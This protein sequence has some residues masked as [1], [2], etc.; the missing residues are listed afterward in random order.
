[1]QGKQKGL[2]ANCFLSKAR[3]FPNRVRA[4]PELRASLALK[5]ELGSITAHFVCG[6][7]QTF[8]KHDTFVVTSQLQAKGGNH[9]Q[10]EH[11]LP[12]PLLGRARRMPISERRRPLNWRDALLSGYGESRNCRTTKSTLPSNDVASDSFKSSKFLES[13]IRPEF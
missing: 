2:I 1:M 12:L 5:T 8:W 6:S 13:D 9:Q 3:S 10:P 11:A 4:L 7:S